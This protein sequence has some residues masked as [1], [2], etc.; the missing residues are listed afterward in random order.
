VAAA[1]SEKS[2]PPTQRFPEAPALIFPAPEIPPAAVLHR[3]PEAAPDPAA[4]AEKHEIGKSGKI[5][6]KKHLNGAC[7]NS[8]TER[9]LFCH[10]ISRIF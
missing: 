5:K 3:E 2:F 4:A 7:G 1:T 8:N 6:Q 10:K 9:M